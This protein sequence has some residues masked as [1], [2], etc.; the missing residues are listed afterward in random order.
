M[1]S[2]RV[3]GQYSLRLPGSAQSCIPQAG[4][5]LILLSPFPSRLQLRLGRCVP[6]PGPGVPPEGLG[7]SPA[8]GEAQGLPLGWEEAKV[9]TQEIS[10]RLTSLPGAKS[11]WLGQAGGES[12]SPARGVHALLL[13]PQPHSAHL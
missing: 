8:E 3:L 2:H 1:L 12:L 13:W 4:K 7:P 11:P 6:G 10:V 5:H 9:R